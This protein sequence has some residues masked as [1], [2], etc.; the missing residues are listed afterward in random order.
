MTN[1]IVNAEA[2]GNTC[3]VLL[4]GGEYRPH[5]WDL[6][7]YLSQQNIKSAHFN[8]SFSG[9]DGIDLV[10]DLMALDMDTANMDH[11]MISQSN[12]VFILIDH[13]KFREKSFI[14]FETNI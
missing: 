9:V 11:L 4:T 14:V 8:K 7:E 1:S 2:L 12:N 3:R 6:A 13:S 10:D 5:R